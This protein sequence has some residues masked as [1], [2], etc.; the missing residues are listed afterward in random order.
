MA[1]FNHRWLEQ[2]GIS[3]PAAALRVAQI[4][5]LRPETQ[6]SSWPIWA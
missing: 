6:P 5:Y 4:E 2:T 1:R 3:D